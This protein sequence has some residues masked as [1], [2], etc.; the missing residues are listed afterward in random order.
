MNSETNKHK[1]KVRKEGKPHDCFLHSK[2]IM[3]TMEYLVSESLVKMSIVFLVEG[4][5][6]ESMTLS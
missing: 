1:N 4:K 6:C 2:M 3:Q 5:Y